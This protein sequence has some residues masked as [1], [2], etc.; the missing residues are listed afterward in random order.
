MIYIEQGI[1]LFSLSDDYM[2]AHCVSADYVLGAGIARQ[3]RRRFDMARK[4][5]ITGTCGSWDDSGRCVIINMTRGGKMTIPQ[6]GELRVANLVTKRYCVNK[7]TLKAIRESLE[8]LRE[9]LQT[10]PEYKNIKRI[11][12]PKIACGLDRQ[13]WSDVSAI[14]QEV[15]D[16]MDIEIRVCTGKPVEY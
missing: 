6:M 14:I 16:S 15:F 13:K 12:M 7:P 2:L 4:L 5:K 8:D 11:G 1:D 3:F 9:Q 10:V